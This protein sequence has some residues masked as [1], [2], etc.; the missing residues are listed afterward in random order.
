MNQDQKSIKKVSTATLNSQTVLLKSS[1]AAGT[2]PGLLG[3]QN[4]SGAKMIG[5]QIGPVSFVDEGIEYI[6][7]TFIHERNWTNLNTDHL[8]TTFILTTQKTRKG[9]CSD[10]T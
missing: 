4:K 7:N 5:I 3:C 6:L 2:L 1:V 9:S 10:T 8:G